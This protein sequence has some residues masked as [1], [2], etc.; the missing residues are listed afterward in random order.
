[1]ERTFGV[2]AN[3]PGSARGSRAGF[4]VSPKQAFSCACHF[5]EK[6]A[7]ARTRSPDTRDAGATQKRAFVL[8]TTR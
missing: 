4:G 7:M 3:I 1:V 8:I 2:A 6:F 5:Q